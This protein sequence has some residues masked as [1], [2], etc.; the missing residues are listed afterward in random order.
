LSETWNSLEQAV[1]TWISHPVRRPFTGSVTPVPGEGKSEVGKPFVADSSYFS[2]RLV[3]MSLAEGGR[4]FTDFLPLGVC[5]T[6]YTIG[7]Q[8]QRSP[9]ILSNDLIAGQLKGTASNPGYVEY[10]NMYAVRQAPVKMD[11]L[12]LFIGLFR[13]PYHD[14]AKQVLQIAADL[15]DLTGI[16]APVAGGLRVAE[17]VYDRVASLF[18]L[19][20]LTPRF[21]F[22]DGNALTESGYLLVAGPAAGEI[23]AGR[24]QVADGK[25]L[26]DGKRASGFD[27]CLVALEHTASLLPQGA[28]SINPLTGLPFH[29]LWRDISKH[30]ALR[31]VATAEAK[32]PQL[33]AEVVVSPAL[34]EEDRLIAIA[35]YDTAYEK[36]R[37]ALAP[38]IAAKPETRAARTLTPATGLHSEAAARGAAGQVLTSQVL[39]EM[40]MRL[41]TPGDAKDDG[42]SVFADE[43]A[44][45]RNALPKLGGRGD[46]RMAASLA[47][48]IGSAVSRHD[49]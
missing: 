29:R 33:R 9:M 7:D 21:G 22:A 3:E 13:M 20:V 23:T 2:V 16:G 26:L 8:R 30:L 46:A 43:V 39:T 41:Q 1:R 15:T 10:V 27:Y 31:E 42:D 19:N 11:N 5:L 32:M 28:G 38:A 48:A 25:L 49:N 17:K 34:T 40:A 44:A 36:L 4:Y 18:Q 14:L 24:L 12:S 47:E 6:E 45:L 35:A 37:T